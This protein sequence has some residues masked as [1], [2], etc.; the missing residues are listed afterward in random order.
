MRCG[1]D[2]RTR[3][4][5]LFTTLILVA[6]LALTLALAVTMTRPALRLPA[7]F[8]ALL[9]IP[10]NVD[11]IVPQMQMDPNDVANN[12]GPAISVIDVLIVWAVFLTLREGQRRW[13]SS[14]HR[15]V[16]LGAVAVAVIG[17][18]AAVTTVALREIEPLAAVRGILTLARIPALVY[19]ATS[20]LSLDPHG[21]RLSVAGA[22]GAVGL[23]GN[24]IYTSAVE[25]HVRFT[26]ATFGRNG[27]GMALVVTGLLAGGAAIQSLRGELDRRLTIPLGL[28]A[29]GAI[30]GSIATGTRMALIAL[31]I[32]TVS[33]VVINRSWWS[34]QRVR[35]LAVGIVAVVVIVVVATVTT[36]GGARTV[37][38]VTDIENTIDTVTNF[39]DQPEY[40]EVR[41]RG[42]FWALAMEMVKEAP[43][44]GVG[45]Y[46]WNIL[47]YDYDPGS[48]KLVANPH[49][50]YFQLA[51]EYGI[52]TLIA[53]LVLLSSVAIMVLATQL[54][55]DSIS[56]RA[57]T[58]SLI[59]GCAAA[60]PVTE[61]TN[62]HL[63]NVRLGAVGWV[64]LGT[65]LAFAL[66]DHERRRSQR[67]ETTATS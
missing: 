55:N 30:Y 52:P 25:E 41:M 24:G 2:I 61:L 60:Y 33:A 17:A 8:L 59:V 50:V 6:G 11:N 63:L 18:I 21:L 47:R 67:G 23:I 40:T 7:L 45:P 51:A 53:Y 57:W 16:L 29:A 4:E 38:T 37:S 3:E 31:I 49:N 36:A 54:R 19:L 39:E 65:V 66:A 26:A 58:A 48:A 34:W 32:G 14:L 9:S 56:A 43:L 46:Q 62:S 28:V 12:T 13:H 44:T 27:L 5:P 20:L 64:L 22:L 10:G 42:Q 15:R 35:H 1:C